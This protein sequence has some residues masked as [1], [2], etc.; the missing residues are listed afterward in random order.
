MELLAENYR[1]VKTELESAARK[2]GRSPDEIK[3]I[4]VTKSASLEDIKQAAGLGITEFGANRVQEEADKVKSLGDVNWHFIGH[5]QRNK[6]KYVMPVYSTVQSLD[7]L[8][9]ARE[10]QRCAEKFEREITVLVQVNISG[11]ESKFGLRPE[12]VGPFLDQAAA[13]D[14]L[15]IKGLMAMA[16]FVDDPEEARCYFRRLRELRDECAAPGLELPELSMGM[17]NDYTVAVEEGATMVRIG[18]AL[19]GRK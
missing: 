2:A 18:G 11:E 15:K 12:E 1:K 3:L 5:L 6:V 9:L 10:L 7:R 14:R 4:A 8:S 19:F 17:T 13:F 16:P